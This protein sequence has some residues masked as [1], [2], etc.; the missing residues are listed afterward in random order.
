M[1]IINKKGQ[2]IFSSTG[3]P[4]NVYFDDS[5]ANLL[6]G[7]TLVHNHPM[8]NIFPKDDFRRTGH[9]L[10]S[11]DLYEAVKCDMN[12]IVTSSSLYIFGK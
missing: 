11:D 6:K 7:N 12:E 3:T 8:G 5:V 4:S 1:Q 9:S 10:S 2:V